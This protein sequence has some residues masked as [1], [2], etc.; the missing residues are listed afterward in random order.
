MELTNQEKQIVVNLLSQISIPVS[1]APVVIEIIKK[2]QPQEIKE[3]KGE[4]EKK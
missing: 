1:Q 3:N 2:L 4:L